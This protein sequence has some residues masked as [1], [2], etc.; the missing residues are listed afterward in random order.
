MNKLNDFVNGYIAVLQEILNIWETVRR[1]NI[2][3]GDCAI[4][5][6]KGLACYVPVTTLT[7]TA[8]CTITSN[9]CQP[10]SVGTNNET[11]SS[12]AVWPTDPGELAAICGEGGGPSYEVNV[13]VPPTGVLTRSYGLSIFGSCDCLTWNYVMGEECE[14]F[15]GEFTWSSCDPLTATIPFTVNCAPPFAP[16]PCQIDG[17]WTITGA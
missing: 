9:T 11:M 16:S 1:Y 4:I 13:N 8:T 5:C 3:M 15:F 10:A 6:E 17:Y 7:L 14:T 2:N 12:G